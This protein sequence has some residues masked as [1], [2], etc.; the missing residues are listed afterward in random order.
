MPSAMIHFSIIFDNREI[1]WLV[2][3][4]ELHAFDSVFFVLVIVMSEA[5]F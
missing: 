4:R 1:T 3:V 5:L 2:V